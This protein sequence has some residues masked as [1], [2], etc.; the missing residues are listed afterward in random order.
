[1]YKQSHEVRLDLDEAEL[2]ATLHAAY[3]EKLGLGLTASTPKSAGDEPHRHSRG[4]AIQRQPKSC[5]WR[6]IRAVPFAPI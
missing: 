2:L 1:M 6:S 3:Q 4:H 5:G